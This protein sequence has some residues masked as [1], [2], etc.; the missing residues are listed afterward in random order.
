MPKQYSHN[1]NQNTIVGISPNVSKF[2]AESGK[3][4]VDLDT[5]K[6]TLLSAEVSKLS[7]VSNTPSDVCADTSL[8]HK[9]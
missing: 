1:C 8:S 6:K 5:I 9:S 7:E 4:S 2:D 3:R